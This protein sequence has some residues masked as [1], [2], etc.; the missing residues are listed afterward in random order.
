M[1]IWFKL[2]GD[3]GFP[4]WTLT[5]SDVEAAVGCCS[6]QR[7]KVVSILLFLSDGLSFTCC[8]WNSCCFSA[9]DFETCWEWRQLLFA[10]VLWSEQFCKNLASVYGTK[11]RRLV[12]SETNGKLHFFKAAFV[13]DVGETFSCGRSPSPAPTSR[14]RKRLP[15]SSQRRTAAS[16]DQIVGGF[17]FWGTIAAVTSSSCCV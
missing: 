8:C 1:H 17:V 7:S 5:L 13:K 3:P 12:K 16:R 10:D 14:S 15:N 11:P 6:K 2:C 4:A 9:A